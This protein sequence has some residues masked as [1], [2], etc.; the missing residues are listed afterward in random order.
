M[1]IAVLGIDIGTYAAKAVTLSNIKGGRATLQ[2]LGMAQLPMD[3]ILNWEDEPVPAKNAISQVMKNMV[4]RLKL[5]GRYVSTS[6][7][8]D[9]IVV[10]K[11]VMPK[12]TPIELK[13]AIAVEAEQYIPF[14]LNEVNL[15]YHI[16]NTSL[17]INQMTVLLVAARKK[18]VQNYMDAI[19]A[20]KLRPAVIDVD[21]LALCNAYEF[22]RPGN[23][24]DVMLVD[25]GAN[26]LNIIALDNGAPL[27]IK[28]E[29]GG[30]QYLTDELGVLFDLD[31]QEVEAI[32]FGQERAPNPGEAADV[33]DRV[34]ANWIAAVE[35]V[36]DAARA[37]NPA[38]KA[39]RIYLSGGS[40]LMPGLTDEF[41]KYFNLETTLFNPLLNTAY[42]AKKIDPEYIK[43][44]GP[45]MAVSFG[46]A[47]RKVE[48]Q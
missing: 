28:D 17:E 19:N 3:L 34:V 44:V 41:R 2:G 23:H 24:D 18:I 47:L 33:V 10:K 43:H 9:S 20:A 16:L 25:I 35:R 8:G 14:S 12:M 30:G 42:N 5:T 38:Y 21:G 39:D 15:S 1:A 26:M 4:S 6:V 36:M 48:V 13:D 45:Q 29:A 37:E 40:S 27:I 31:Q 22:T 11:I 46:L 32:K 7:S